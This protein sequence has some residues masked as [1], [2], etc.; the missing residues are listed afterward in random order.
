MSI[1]N[2]EKIFD[3]RCIAVIGADETPNSA[4][5]TVFHNLIASNYQGVVYPVNP[6]YEVV[7]ESRPIGYPEYSRRGRPGRNLHA[8]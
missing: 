6:K 1:R 8:G 4:G 2:L 5:S 7:Q 3:P